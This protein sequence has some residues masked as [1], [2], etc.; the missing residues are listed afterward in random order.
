MPTGYTSPLYDNKPIT[1]PEFIMRCARAM[2]AYVMLKDEP[3][4]SP[5]PGDWEPQISWREQ[6][7]ADAQET[8]ATASQWTPAEATEEANNVYEEAYRVWLE[9]GRKRLEL[10]GRYE[11]MLG[12]VKGWEPPTED[13]FGLKVFME[14]QLEESIKFD[15]STWDAPRRKTGAAHRLEVVRKATRE[16]EYQTEEIEKEKER[17][18]SRNAWTRAL[19]ENVAKL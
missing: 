15:C 3:L 4:D 10:L 5:D 6:L 9:E 18:E 1:F 13:H 8:L 17:T 7:L 12:L 14:D 16:I 2:G 11:Y 19:K